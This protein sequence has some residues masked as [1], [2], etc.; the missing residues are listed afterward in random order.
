MHLNSIIHL[1]D[2]IIE[3]RLFMASRPDNSPARAAELAAIPGC[4]PPAEA[5]AA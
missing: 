2:S 1:L 3:F 5:A 4:L